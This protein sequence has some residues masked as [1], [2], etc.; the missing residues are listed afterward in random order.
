MRLLD[1]ILAIIL[2]LGGL[3]HT[4]GT[5][6]LMHD[7]MMQLWSLGTSLFIFHIRDFEPLSEFPAPRILG[8][9]PSA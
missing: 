2:L 8:S 5:F 1:R 7:P 6:L 3:G 9:L 4:A